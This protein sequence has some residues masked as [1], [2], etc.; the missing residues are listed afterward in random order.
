ME[1]NRAH[2]IIVEVLQNALAGKL[3]ANVNLH[4]IADAIAVKVNFEKSYTNAKSDQISGKI[5][6]VVL[7]RQEE[8]LQEME[9]TTEEEK[10]LKNFIR[11]KLTAFA[12]VLGD[13]N[14]L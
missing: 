4:D 8:T 6:D 5:M 12:E 10:L 9:K 11:G 14:A 3:S 1:T 2:E 7:A 13:I